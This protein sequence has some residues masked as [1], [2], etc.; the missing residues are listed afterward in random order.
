MRSA[1]AWG[2]VTEPVLC[3]DTTVL[4]KSL[5][6]EEPAE[7][8]EAAKELVLLGVMGGRLVAPAFAWAE[9]GSVLRKKVRLGVLES[10]QAEAIWTQVMRLPIE[11][12]E[13]PALRS[14]AW[15]L[16]E[17]YGLPTLYDAAFL[18]C[19]E[20]APAEEPAV[21]EFWTADEELLRHLRSSMPPYVRQLGHSRDANKP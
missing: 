13:S 20:V 3:L 12:I 16:A 19:A 14:R 18:A 5:V 9:L 10:S 1:K 8:E 4:I 15:A 7:L 17:Q 21:R 6:P 2:G 11:F